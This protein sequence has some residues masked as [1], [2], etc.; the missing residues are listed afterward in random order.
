M[1]D[2]MTLII[3]LIISVL[4]LVILYAIFHEAREYVAVSSCGLSFDVL[5]QFPNKQEAADIFCKIHKKLIAVIDNLEQKYG[6]DDTRVKLLKKNYQNTDLTETMGQTETINK[7]EG[8]FDKI[9]IKLR[10]NDG[11]FYDFNTIMFVILH[12]FTHVSIPGFRDSNHNE[13]FWKANGQMLRDARE[14]GAISLVDYAK[15]PE[16]YDGLVIKNNPGLTY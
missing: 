1:S 13:A 11:T 5:S 10:K 2:D 15:W 8:Y 9:Y 14:I 6:M 4:V 12:E 3:V 7:T 16:E